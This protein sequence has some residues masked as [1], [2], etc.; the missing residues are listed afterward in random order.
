[1][2]REDGNLEDVLTSLYGDVRGGGYIWAVTSALTYPPI[3]KALVDA[4]KRG[5]TFG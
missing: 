4:K 1:M 5:S 3:A 2:S